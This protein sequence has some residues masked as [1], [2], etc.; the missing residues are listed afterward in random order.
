MSRP[1]HKIMLQNET[2]ALVFTVING[3]VLKRANIW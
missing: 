1:A 2:L 3:L